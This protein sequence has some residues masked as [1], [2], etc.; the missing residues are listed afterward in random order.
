VRMRDLVT[1]LRTLAADFAY[2]CHDKLQLAK[3]FAGSMTTKQVHWRTSSI[4]AMSG[5]RQLSVSGT[6]AGIDQSAR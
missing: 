6:A 4:A 1:E 5:R 3:L 2:L